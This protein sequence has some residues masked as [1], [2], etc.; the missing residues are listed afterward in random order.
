MKIIAKIINHI[1]IVM[2]MRPAC[3]TT[4]H[5]SIGQPNKRTETKTQAL[6]LNVAK[7]SNS[8]FSS[9]L[10]ATSTLMEFPAANPTLLI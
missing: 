8:E 5:S 4:V 10:T 9:L 7:F 3:Y 1:V 6:T 2:S